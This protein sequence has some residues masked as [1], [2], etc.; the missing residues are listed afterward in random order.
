[1]QG[2]FSQSNPF[3]WDITA[4]Q[5]APDIRRFDNGTPGCI[6]AIASLPAMDWHAGQD[7]AALLAHNRMLTERLFILADD[8]R[9]ESLTPRPSHQRGG[10]VMLRLPA[11][12]PAAD[13]VAALSAQGISTDHRGQTL[14][15][16]PGVLT[17]TAGTDHLHDTLKRLLR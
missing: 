3:N 11:D 7:K 14:R 1:M 17:T 5:A 12:R 4:F 6:A 2:W 16:S 13:I 8:L 9:L 15:L 10:S